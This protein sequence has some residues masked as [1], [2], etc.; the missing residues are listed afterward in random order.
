MDGL[1]R[2]VLDVNTLNSWTTHYPGHIYGK[3]SKVDAAIS[4]GLNNNKRLYSKKTKH[5]K[6]LLTF[7]LK[8]KINGYNKY[9]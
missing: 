9:M 1:I 5:I 7:K 4:K 2:G 8:T 6:N 3:A